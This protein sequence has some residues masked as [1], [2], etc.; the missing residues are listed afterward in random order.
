[1][2]IT[3]VNEDQAIQVSDRRLSG[4]GADPGVINKATFFTCRDAAMSVAFTG[5]ATIRDFDAS[6]WIVDALAECGGA[7]HL[8]E[9]TLLGVRERLSDVIWQ[10]P[11]ADPRHRALS[12][13]FAGFV[14][15][16]D[17]PLAFAAILSNVDHDAT[18]EPAEIPTREFALQTFVEKR[19][20]VGP[21][22]MLLSGGVK[23][24]VHPDDL[25]DL[26]EALLHRVPAEAIVARAI[27]VVRRAAARPA[28]RDLIGR[29]CMSIVVPRDGSMATAGYHPNTRDPVSYAPN[30]VRSVGDG[31]ADGRFVDFQM[32]EL[33]D[34]G[35]PVPR[36]VPKVGRQAMPVRLGQEAQEVP[37]RDGELPGTWLH[38]GSGR[39]R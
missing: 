6:R 32:L 19:P 30:F 26:A 34:Q 14:D 20:V 5:L 38:R 35:R 4:P 29:D 39:S 7:D 37:R 22:R 24:A 23:V 21:Q 10:L 36:G 31:R 17:P 1:M 16:A 13:H 33:D 2:I 3:A 28:A 8:L 11:V 18:K 25:E 9:T 15:R 27:A 12:F